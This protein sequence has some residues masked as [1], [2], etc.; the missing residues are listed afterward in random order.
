MSFL[1]TPPEQDLDDEARALRERAAATSPGTPTSNTKAALL[2]H[3][4]SL[5][6]YLEWYTLRDELTP[7]IGARGVTLFGLAISDASGSDVCQ[8][9]FRSQLADAGEDPDSPVLDERDALLAD[10]GRLVV[11]A[12]GEIPDDVYSRLEQSF[13]PWQRVLLVAFAGLMVATNIFNMVGRVP[14]D[15]ALRPFQR[16]QPTEPEIEMGST[17]SGAE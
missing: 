1:P 5:N 9:Y 8:S 17:E 4:P 10:L 2:G 7:V 6:A 15:L 13:E 3:A 11:T 16:A 14:V 12:P